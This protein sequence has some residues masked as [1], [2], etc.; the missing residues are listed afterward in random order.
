MV[1]PG[2]ARPVFLTLGIVLAASVGRAQDRPQPPA[3]ERAT[4][5]LKS[6]SVDLPSGDAFPAGQG[7]EVMD[8]NCLGCHSA[9]MVLNQPALTRAA[10]E[11]EVH[12]MIEVYKA[13]VSADDVPAIVDY[14]QRTKGV[15]PAE[16]ASA[17]PK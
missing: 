2:N 11:K 9:G 15:K 12:K 8:S 10:W 7:W 5:V 1:R 6:V 17:T 4:L 16:V 14:L 13:S 3:P